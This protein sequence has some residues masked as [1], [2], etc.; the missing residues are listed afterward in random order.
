[1]NNQQI[2]TKPTFMKLYETLNKLDLYNINPNKNPTIYNRCVRLLSLCYQS[3]YDNAANYTGCLRNIETGTHYHDYEI[4]KMFDI[5]LR[6]YERLFNDLKAISLKSNPEVKMWEEYY[7]KDK[8]YF[9]LVNPD[10]WFYNT[11]EFGIINDIPNS[12]TQE[13][14]VKTPEH[15]EVPNIVVDT[16]DTGRWTNR[17]RKDYDKCNKEVYHYCSEFKFND[18]SEIYETLA[19]TIANLL[20]LEELKNL[21]SY[22]ENNY[23]ETPVSFL[24]HLINTGS[25]VNLINDKVR[26]TNDTVEFVVGKPDQTP[27]WGKKL[28]SDINFV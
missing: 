12:S 22:V 24:N 20:N 10:F 11:D 9:K 19:I 13:E 1:M 6:Q 4:M 23:R 28:Q 14:D 26:S 21:L 7:H 15:K 17:K 3:K 8:R 18:G 5:S 16:V 27:E 2:K 25:Y